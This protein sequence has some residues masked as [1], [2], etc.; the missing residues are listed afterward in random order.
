MQKGVGTDEVKKCSKVSPEPY[1]YRRYQVGQN[2][3]V[4]D[5]N[6][7]IG[8][9]KP[10]LECVPGLE[11]RSCFAWFICQ[12]CH[13]GPGLLLGIGYGKREEASLVLRVEFDCCGGDKQSRGTLSFYEAWPQS[14]GGLLHKLVADAALR[15]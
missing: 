13:Y 7:M 3:R 5:R 1:R 6:A 9:L 8:A 10:D 2:L 4:G 12:C 15:E 11:F 14:L